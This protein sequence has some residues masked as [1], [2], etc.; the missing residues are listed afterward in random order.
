LGS[1]DQ[2]PTQNVLWVYDI[3]LAQRTGRRQFRE[4]VVTQDLLRALIRDPLVQ[5]NQQ[6][7]CLHEG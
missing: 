1:A 2:G 7:G 6:L 4:S 3:S 5:D